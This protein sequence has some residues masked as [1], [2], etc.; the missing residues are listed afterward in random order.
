M[1]ISLS[2]IKRSIHEWNQGGFTTSCKPPVT[3]R[4]R[5]PCTEKRKTI[6]WTDETNRAMGEEKHRDGEK[7]FMT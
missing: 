7:R 4:N 6:L 5:K 3:F 1:G 2:T